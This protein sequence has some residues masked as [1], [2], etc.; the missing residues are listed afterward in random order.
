VAPESRYAPV[1]LLVDTNVLIR[2]LTGDPPTQA[3]RATAFLRGPHELILTDLV[4]AEMVY[5]LESYYEL[6]RSQV[7]EAARS[8]LAFP[9]ISVVDVD[10]LLRAIELYDTIRLDFAEAYLIAAAEVS[11]AD[12]VAS[13]D[14]RVDRVTTARRVEP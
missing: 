8:L 1:R 2:H 5:V 4:L 12:G 10:L 14:R 3:K 6:P 7:A 11:D 9:S 13:F